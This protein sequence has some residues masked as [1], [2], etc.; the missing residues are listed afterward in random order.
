MGAIVTSAG[1]LPPHRCKGRFPERPFSLCICTEAAVPN[2]CETLPNNLARTL[3]RSSLGEAA[4]VKGTLLLYRPGKREPEVSDFALEPSREEVERAIGGRFDMIAGFLSIEHCG[5]VRR[6][7]AV[8][9]GDA[10]AKNAPLNVTATLLWDA[11]LRRDFGIT[12][13]RADGPRADALF[14]SIAVLFL[15]NEAEIANQKPEIGSRRSRLF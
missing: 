9:D 8:A 7:V 12:L 15:H 6:C 2:A 4:P 14:G 13:V 11:A 5:I 1:L 10:R 3:H